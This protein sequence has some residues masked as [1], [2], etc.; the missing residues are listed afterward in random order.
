M[1]KSKHKKWGW[2]ESSSFLNDADNARIYTDRSSEC[3][4]LPGPQIP[5]RDNRSPSQP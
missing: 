2:K 4:P 1:F 3:P 5:A